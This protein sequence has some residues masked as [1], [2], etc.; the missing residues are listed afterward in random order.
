MKTCFMTSIN[1]PPVSM[2]IFTLIEPSEFS[3][4]FRPTVWS[5]VM[6]HSLPV[7]LLPADGRSDQVSLRCDLA[8]KLEGQ[9]TSHFHFAQNKNT[10]THAHFLR[11]SLPR[12][13]Q[14]TGRIRQQPHKWRWRKSAVSCSKGGKPSDKHE[15]NFALNSFSPHSLLSWFIFLSVRLSVCRSSMISVLCVRDWCQNTNLFLLKRFCI[16]NTV[17]HQYIFLYLCKNIFDFH[18]IFSWRTNAAVKLGKKKLP[19]NYVMFY[20]SQ[21][22]LRSE[23]LFLSSEKLKSLISLWSVL[24]CLYKQLC[25]VCCCSGGALSSLITTLMM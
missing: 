4:L 2:F 16:T 23:L 6:R 25:H 18:V 7:W 8:L 11:H 20:I 10:P 17:V 15:V 5:L 22:Q 24:L 21:F 14:Y 1:F 19:E 3:S 13:G 9:T 12:R